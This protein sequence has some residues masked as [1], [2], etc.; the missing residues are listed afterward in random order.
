[1]AISSRRLSIALAISVLL[2]APLIAEPIRVSGQVDLPDDS[3]G[4]AGVQIELLPA[5]ESFPEAVRRL[6][7]GTEP[8]PLATAHTD[9]DGFYELSAPEAGVYRLRLQAAGYLTEEIQLSPLFEDTDVEG[10]HLTP[11]EPVDVRVI[12]GDGK[13]L[14]GLAAAFR[15]GSWDRT[16]SR[17][18]MRRSAGSRRAIRGAA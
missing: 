3:H 14:S 4:A 17:S 16:A 5:W 2:S 11:A 15:A 18:G 1:M 12:S 8:R 10:D 6:R 7:E 9:K 13:P